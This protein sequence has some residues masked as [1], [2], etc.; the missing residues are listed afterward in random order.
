M[1]I[2]SVFCF[3]QDIQDY[4]LAHSLDSARY[5]GVLLIFFMRWL[6][7][8][9][10]HMH[11]YMD[12]Y[13]ISVRGSLEW[14]IASAYCTCRDCGVFFSSNFTVTR[15]FK[16]LMYDYEDVHLSRPTTPCSVDRPL[17][18]AHSMKLV[19]YNTQC[20]RLFHGQA[21]E[22]FLPVLRSVCLGQWL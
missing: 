19:V 17:H 13:I 2:S 8:D 9:M 6:I 15:D 11:N 20:A 5:S 14:I 12:I 3:L 7:W 4:N 18:P 21:A 10:P 22:S 1:C 16:L